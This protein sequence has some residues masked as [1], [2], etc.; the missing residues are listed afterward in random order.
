MVLGDIEEFGTRLRINLL[1]VGVVT[2][3]PV[4]LDSTVG[5]TGALLRVRMPAPELVTWLGRARAPFALFQSIAARV[6]ARPCPLCF[7]ILRVV[8]PFLL[9]MLA[10]CVWSTG[11][12]A[13]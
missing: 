9:V 11:F 13:W 4:L 6:R 1:S 2:K 12:Y 8:I 10:T 3:D 7:F 5:R